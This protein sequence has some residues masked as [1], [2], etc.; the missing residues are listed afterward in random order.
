MTGSH[1]GSFS[2]TPMAVTGLTHE[3]TSPT[4]VS[5]GGAATGKRIHKPITITMRFDQSTPRFLSALVSNEDLT[6]S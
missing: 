1:Q 6:R 4:D 5:S 2:S 3:I